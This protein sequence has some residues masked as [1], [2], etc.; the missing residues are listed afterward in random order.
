MQNAE[1]GAFLRA[2][3]ARL[4][5]DGEEI[6]DQHIGLAHRRRVPGLRRE[7]VALLAGVSVDYYARLEQ[8]RTKQVSREVLLAIASALELDATEQ[9][10]F[11]TLVAAQTERRRDGAATPTS[12]EHVRPGVRQLLASL[13]HSAAFVHGLGMQ[14]LAMN[15]LATAL[16]AELA[17]T[18]ARDRNFVRW[19][20]LGATPKE[21]FDDWPTAAAEMSAVLRVDSGLHPDDRALHELVGLL[22]NRSPEFRALWHEHRVRECAFDRVQVHHPVAGT[23]ALDYESLAVPGST[24][25]HLVAYTAPAGSP[26][27]EAL[28]LLASWN[29]P[30]RP[31]AALISE[32][33]ADVP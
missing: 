3:R 31:P 25:Q 19:V 2:R 9:D 24:A 14:V 10:Y 12:V 4:R 20:F 30:P 7:E 23:L 8:G 29:A 27:E 5:P 22:A 26:A 28:A 17:S 6:G 15:P 18:P 1:L 13:D 33:A 16:F 11:F 32:N 21:L